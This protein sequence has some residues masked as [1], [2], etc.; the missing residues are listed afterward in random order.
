MYTKNKGNDM[1]NSPCG[2]CPPCCEEC[3]FDSEAGTG[4]SLVQVLVSKKDY[5]CVKSHGAVGLNSQ[6]Q[7]GQQRS[8]GFH[9]VT[10]EGQKHL[11]DSR[12]LLAQHLA[13]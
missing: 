10:V 6:G 11:E 7:L 3:V 12:N 1:A 5:G 13:A 2:G 9:P 8:T 4:G